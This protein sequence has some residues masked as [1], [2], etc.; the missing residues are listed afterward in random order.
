MIHCTH[1]LPRASV[2]LASQIGAR[3]LDSRTVVV[4]G[5]RFAAARD[6]Y[7]RY[8]FGAPE[9]RVIVLQP[10]SSVSA[11]AAAAAESVGENVMAG[12]PGSRKERVDRKSVV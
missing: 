11:D 3:T 10:A 5:G 12:T 4:E 8:E 6:V 2:T 1:E 9:W 7:L